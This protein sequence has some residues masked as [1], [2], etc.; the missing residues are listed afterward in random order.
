MFVLFFIEFFFFDD[1]PR[2][3]LL[4]IVFAKD[5]SLVHLVCFYKALAVFKVAGVVK[6]LILVDVFSILLLLLE[7]R[8]IVESQF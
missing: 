4:L 2:V 3:V 7:S 1:D 8:Y 6:V 5:M